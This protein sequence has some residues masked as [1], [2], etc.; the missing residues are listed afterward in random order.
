[1]AIFVAGLAVILYLLGGRW[2]GRGWLPKS[3]YLVGGALMLLFFLYH[4]AV[5]F[6]LGAGAIML[7]RM[8]PAH[9]FRKQPG[10]G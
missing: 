4:A 1:M 10:E 3:V 8:L 6:V 5:L 7:A 2:Q 9:G